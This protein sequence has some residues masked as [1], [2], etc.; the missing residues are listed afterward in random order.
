MESSLSSILA[1]HAKEI[2]VL[3][4]VDSLIQLELL[5][6]LTK[7]LEL[8]IQRLMEWNSSFS[9][10]MELSSLRKKGENSSSYRAKIGELVQ[11]L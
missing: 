8:L 6:L 10:K 3:Q 9:R 7:L 1:T 4:P 5:F 2:A 11:I